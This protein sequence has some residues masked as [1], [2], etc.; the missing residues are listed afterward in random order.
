MSEFLNII[1]MSSVKPLYNSHPGFN[2]STKYTY[3]SIALGPSSLAVLQS[4]L[5][6]EIKL[7]QILGG[8][9]IGV[10]LTFKFVINFVISV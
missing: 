7:I 1:I 3:I 8:H 10:P 2:K 9:L 4:R 6:V 5:L